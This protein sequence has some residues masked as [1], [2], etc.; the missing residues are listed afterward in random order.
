MTFRIGDGAIHVAIALHANYKI[1][2]CFLE[3]AAQ[4]S[5]EQVSGLVL[6]TCYV[7]AGCT[8]W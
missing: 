2:S 8:D 5:L 4:K 6:D 1:D 3:K 7:P